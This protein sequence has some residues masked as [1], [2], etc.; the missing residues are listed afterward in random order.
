LE[1]GKTMARQ[2]DR[3]YKLKQ[4]ML[5]ACREVI[6]EIEEGLKETDLN[7][8]LKCDNAGGEIDLKLYDQDIEINLEKISNYFATKGNCSLEHAG[9][10][11]MTDAVKGIVAR[12][13]ELK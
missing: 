2:L 3:K 11:D 13:L 12:N 10:E 7:A 4:M 6:S 9:Q 5:K 1:W 8:D